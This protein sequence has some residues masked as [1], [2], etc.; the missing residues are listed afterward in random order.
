[1]AQ[2]SASKSSI[3]AGGIDMRKWHLVGVVRGALSFGNQVHKSRKSTSDGAA[4]TTGEAA[5]ASVR[6]AKVAV[7]GALRSIVNGCAEKQVSLPDLYLLIC[8]CHM[9]LS[10][11]H[12]TAVIRSSAPWGGLLHKHTCLCVCV[13]LHEVGVCV[14]ACVFH[15]DRQ[16]PQPLYH[17]LAS[18]ISG[19]CV[20]V[21]V[22]SQWCVCVRVFLH[23]LSMPSIVIRSH[24]RLCRLVGLVSV[25]NQPMVPKDKAK[26]RG[27]SG[28]KAFNEKRALVRLHAKEAKAMG[29]G[30]LGW[31]AFN[32]KHVLERTRAREAKAMASG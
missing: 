26:R 28:W 18:Q 29:Q 5:H 30:K 10:F 27:K 21:C 16:Y 23:L 13:C 1:M 20:C 9:Q 12:R 24:F 32:E 7:S 11:C 17:R 4:M 6:H 22:A 31:K 25:A 15:V 14:R 19:V 2:I 8:F 3:G